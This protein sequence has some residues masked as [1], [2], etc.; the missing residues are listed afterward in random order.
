MHNFVV[1]SNES[2]C[3]KSGRLGLEQVIIV[4]SVRVSYVARNG[5][6]YWTGRIRR[7]YRSGGGGGDCQCIGRW[8]WS[9]WSLL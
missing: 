6:N 1:H 3:R 8:L 2:A 4:Y 7:R 9:V 5:I